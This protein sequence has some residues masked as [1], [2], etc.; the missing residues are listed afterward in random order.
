MP[1][2]KKEPDVDHYVVLNVDP[3][4][5]LAVVSKA[6]KKLALKYHPDKTAKLNEKEKKEATERFIK[7]KESWAVLSDEKAKAEYDEKLKGKLARSEAERKRFG[8]Q[9]TDRARMKKDLERREME[10]S[11]QK[12]QTSKTAWMGD[13]NSAQAMQKEAE[14]MKE[15]Y[16]TLQKIKQTKAR[17]KR[18]KE[19]RSLK[20]KWKKSKVSHSEDSL[21]KLLRGYGDVEGVEMSDKGNAASVTFSSDKVDL[22]KAVF[23]YE[24]DELVRLTF[25][26]D[27]KKSASQ[28]KPAAAD[29][30]SSSSKKVD[31]S[32]ETVEQMKIRQARERR[33]MIKK[34]EAEDEGREYVPSSDEEEGGGED[35]EE[36]EDIG[37]GGGGERTLKRKGLQFPTP[38]T[39][40]TAKQKNMIN[41]EMLLEREEAV[42]LKLNA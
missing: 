17:E 28:T 39:R 14:Q 27:R 6:Y 15:S 5:H 7:I 21:V 41:S 30:A 2:S 13:K 35:V 40:S 33:R 34:M 1:P 16:A 26:G 19:S 37:D 22:E 4:S 11:E 36:G 29:S 20:V 42:F 24:K 10:N 32:L 23:D 9:D 25:I 8:D 38:F 18:E 3:L 31:R 12:H